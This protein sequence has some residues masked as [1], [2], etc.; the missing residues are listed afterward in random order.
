M[1]RI[2]WKLTILI[3]LIFLAASVSAIEDLTPSTPG[4]NPGTQPV[5]F[6]PICAQNAAGLSRV[7]SKLVDVEAAANSCFKEADI[8]RLEKELDENINIRLNLFLGQMVAILLVYTV[9][10]FALIFLSKAKGYS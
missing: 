3:T 9:F 2:T 10:F 4:F 1:K 6:D 5:T 7:E 8:D